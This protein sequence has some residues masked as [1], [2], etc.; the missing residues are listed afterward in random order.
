[1][2]CVLTKTKRPAN[3]NSYNKTEMT[4]IIC[5][6]SHPIVSGLLQ[7]LKMWYKRPPSELHEIWLLSSQTQAAHITQSRVKAATHAL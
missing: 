7:I 4:V 2:L 3:N 5:V 6:F 1:M